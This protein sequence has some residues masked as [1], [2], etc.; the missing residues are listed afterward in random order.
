MFGRTR[1]AFLWRLCAV[2]EEVKEKETTSVSEVI[3]RAAE[4]ARG[5][6]VLGSST[7]CLCLVDTVRG[8]A[9]VAHLGDSGVL[10]VGKEGVVKLKTPQ[11]EHSFGFPFQLGHHDRSDRPED[12]LVSVVSVEAGDVIVVGSDGLFDNLSDAE[13]AACAIEGRRGGGRGT[14][15]DAG[16]MAAAIANELGRRAF[17]NSLDKKIATP[18]SIAATEAFSMIYSGGKSDDITIVVACIV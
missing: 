17:E 14:R 4:S 10:I 2:S 1:V 12:A 9:Q 7:I 6:G 3:K 5:A 15:A 13:V 11:Q 8:T 18:Y 16:A